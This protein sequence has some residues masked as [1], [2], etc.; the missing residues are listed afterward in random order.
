MPPLLELA[1]VFLRLGLTAFGGPAAHVAMMEA[2]VVRRRQWLTSERFLDLFGAANLLPG[3][4]SSELAIFIGYER[5]GGFGLLVAGVCF[6]LPAALLAAGLAAAYVRFGALPQ[7]TGL[8]YGVK[9]VIIAIVAQA[10]WGLLPKA[11]KSPPLIAIGLVAFVASACGVSALAVFGGAGLLAVASSRLRSRDG[12]VSSFAAWLGSSA[13]GASTPITLLG[14]FFVFLKLGALVFGSGYVLVAFL[15]EDLVTRLHWLTE[16]Q[17]LDAVAVGQVTPGPVFT[18][19]TFIGYLL[20]GPLGA[21]L[22]TVAIFL[23]GFVFVA[24]GRPLL[25]RVRRSAV[26]GVF[27]DGVNAAALAVMCM[28]TAQLARAAIVDALTAVLALAALA[29]LRRNINSIWLIT[30][31]ALLGVAFALYGHAL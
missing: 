23:P 16:R 6:I 4:S 27:L 18:T 9:P 28:A 19:A 29:A 11:L 12:Q 15:R 10:I 30:A 5:A 7:V 26:A 24:L 3:P 22:A 13:L 17:L 2:E 25:V 1:A 14:I 31:G 21:L 8:L 20:A